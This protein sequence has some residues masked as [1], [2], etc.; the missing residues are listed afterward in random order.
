MLLEAQRKHRQR[1]FVPLTVLLR[2]YWKAPIVVIHQLEV[3][4]Q[5]GVFFEQP[6]RSLDR[7]WAAKPSF[8]S[9]NFLVQ[10]C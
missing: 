6:L 2:L 10:Q 7:R 1:S 9:A 8:N 3:L 4:F 5:A